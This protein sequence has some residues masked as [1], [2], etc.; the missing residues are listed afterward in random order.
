MVIL[1][2][3]WF[4]LQMRYKALTTKDK[5]L[6]EWVLERRRISK[7]SPHN[8][9]NIPFKNRGFMW[10]FWSV[11]NFFQP[12]CIHCGCSIKALSLSPFDECVPGEWPELTEEQ[13]FNS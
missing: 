12:F 6:P 5:D 8:S 4:I 3:L 1:S 2:K 10:Y 11:L 13:I 9:K 7:D